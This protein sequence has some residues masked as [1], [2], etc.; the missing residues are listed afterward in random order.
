MT[1]TTDQEPEGASPERVSR[2]RL[3]A[4]AGVGGAGA[5]ASAGI[6]VGT[7]LGVQ[8]AREP[9]ERSIQFGADVE[10]F[11]GPRQ[12]GITTAPQAH[13]VFIALDLCEGA[14][15]RSIVRLLRLLSDDAARLTAGEPALADTEPELALTP[16]SMTVTF[17]FG[18]RLVETLSPGAV[19]EWLEELPEFRIDELDEELCG[20]D[21]GLQLCG[22]DPVSLAHARRMLLK[23]A[24]PY[25]RPRWIQEGFRPARGVHRP[26][27]THRN[28]FGQ[29]D[30]TVQP[31]A[32]DDGQEFVVWG[33]P[34][35]HLD[36][37]IRPWIEGGTSMV[38]RLIRMDLDGWDELARSGK[39]AAIGR[40]LSGGA[41][42]T[43]EH[44]H[45]AADFD[46]TT[47]LGFP[48]IEESAHMRRARAQSPEEQMLRRSYSYDRPPAGAGISDSGQLF[49]AFQADV[50]RQFLP[51]QRRLAELDRL[52]EW[53]TP[54][55]SAV[56]AVPPGCAPGG[57]IGDVLG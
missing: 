15:A 52:N 17:G 32:G 33:H 48:V 34:P 51:V 56:F 19:P 8:A 7:V 21:L 20:G 2:R 55:G 24:R 28:L 57:Y 26:G 1:R 49:I 18:R 14:D 43:G 9:Q 40:D 47:P 44:E 29:V 11:H 39:E 46:A 5:L 42:L 23:D 16:A 45:D 38:V 12:A 36:S 50:I 54:I 30:G 27:V 6:G 41:P 53:T 22:D 37:P 31:T 25:A 35:Q 13:L 3:L 4:T 10:P